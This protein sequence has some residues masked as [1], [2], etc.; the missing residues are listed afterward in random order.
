MSKIKAFSKG[1]KVICKN[2]KGV[3]NPIIQKKIRSPP[4]TRNFEHKY[5]KAEQGPLTTVK[6]L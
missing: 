3:A 2:Y 1:A 5:G 6:L 4:L